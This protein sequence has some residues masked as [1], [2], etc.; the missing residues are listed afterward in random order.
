MGVRI[1]DVAQ[2]RLEHVIRAFWRRIEI[3]KNDHGKALGP[4][5]P[6]YFR[7][8]FA[9]ALCALDWGNGIDKAKILQEMGQD[10][11]EPPDGGAPPEDQDGILWALYKAGYRKVR[12]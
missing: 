12:L 8:A 9:T 1:V 5:L 7:T 2:E 4:K 10:L 6:V 3:Y 11:L